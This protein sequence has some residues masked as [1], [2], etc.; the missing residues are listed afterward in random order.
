MEF[1]VHEQVV[2]SR[3]ISQA[4]VLCSWARHFTLSA[5]L[6]Q[7]YKWVPINFMLVHR[8]ATPSIKLTL[9]IYAPTAAPT[10]SRPQ[11]PRSF[12]SALNITTSGLTS[13][14]GAVSRKPR[15]LFGPVKPLQNLEPCD[16]R[17]AL[18]ACSKNEG[19]FPSYKRLQAYTLLRFRIQII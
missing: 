17:A 1:K 4:M 6:S 5:P 16:Y 10:H 12:W 8:R 11:R 14:Q 15:K 18:F 3:K 19:R 7:A 13:G 2:V 9:P